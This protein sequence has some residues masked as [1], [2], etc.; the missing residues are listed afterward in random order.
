[1]GGQDRVGSKH[2]HKGQGQGMGTKWQGA[3]CMVGAKIR[4]GQ[5][6]GGQGQAQAWGKQEA[7]DLWWGP[8][9]LSP[10]TTFLATSSRRDKLKMSFH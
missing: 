7:G 5:E 2:R 10:V 6:L 3:R 4:G 1:M 9:P 8:G